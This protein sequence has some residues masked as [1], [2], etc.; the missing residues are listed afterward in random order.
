ML[1]VF[2]FK[3]EAINNIKNLV[4]Q[5]KNVGIFSC[6]DPYN[7]PFHR[8]ILEL[9]DYIHLVP[10]AGGV[11]IP[12]SLDLGLQ[13]KGINAWGIFGHYGIIHGHELCAAIK[14][15][16]GDYSQYGPDLRKHISVLSEQ[17]KYQSKKS[18]RDNV[19]DWVKNQYE[20]LLK[21]IPAK[22]RTLKGA[23][24]GDIVIFGGLVENS[25]DA[26]GYKAEVL[27]MNKK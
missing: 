20:L 19:I 16:S 6:E 26:K 1:K 11:V 18:L 8:D 21:L 24:Q 27:F 4:E 3:M 25:K 10:K 17:Y 9:T 2:K 7:T 12:E 23:V 14:A 22:Q 5:G 13:A 15:L